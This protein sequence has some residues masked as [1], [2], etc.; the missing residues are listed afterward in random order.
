MSDGDGDG[1]YEAELKLADGVHFYKF[2][3]NGNQWHTDPRSDKDLEQP[4]GHGGMNSAV[5]IGPDVRK[6]PPPKPGH[7]NTE[8]ITFRADDPSDVNLFARG[9]ARF[10][11]RAQAGDVTSVSVVD[12]RGGQALRR[13]SKQGGMDVFGGIVDLSAEAPL[14]VLRLRDG[15][16]EIWLD[17]NGLQSQRASSATVPQLTSLRLPVA[18]TFAT[19]EWAKHAVWYQIFPERFRNGDP[20]NDPG[21]KDYER[22]VRWQSDWWETQPNETPGE[23]NFYKGQGNVW[24]RRY[25]GDIQGVKQALPYLRRLGVNAIYFNPVFEA[26]SMHKYDASDFRHID[27]NF[28]KKGDI[29]YLRRNRRPCDVAVER[30]GQDLPRLRAGG[31]QAGLQ[32]HHRRRVQPRRAIAPVLPGR[33]QAGQK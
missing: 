23:E 31:A 22:L 12:F 29:L 33:P 21:D 17:A 26:D 4:D 9:R 27:D 16:E 6:L 15:D 8:G 18:P 14:F 10:R 32:G 5:L 19:P 11:V 7:V 2:V 13:V 24:K 30:V 1:V 20:S 3:V 25:G 28:G